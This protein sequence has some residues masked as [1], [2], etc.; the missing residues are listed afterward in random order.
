[1]IDFA[2]GL[3][4]SEMFTV[5]NNFDE[6][7]TYDQYVENY[8]NIKKTLDSVG[9]YTVLIDENGDVIYP[10]E[11]KH[12]Y[13]EDELLSL[14]K[15][16][17][18]IDGNDFESILIPLKDRKNYSQLTIIPADKLHTSYSLN[19]DIEDKGTHPYAYMIL[20]GFLI[21]I[22]GTIITMRFVLVSTDRKIVE[23]ILDLKRDMAALS[24]PSYDIEEKTYDIVELNQMR[25]SFEDMAYTLKDLSDKT[26]SDEFLRSKLISELGHD[27]KNAL[28]PLVGYTN[29]LKSRDYI[30]K[31]D[32]KI[33]QAM[34]DDYSYIEIMLRRLVDYGKLR[35]IDYH[36]N[37]TNVDIVELYKSIIVDKYQN[38]ENKGIDQ[39]IEIE[40]KSIEVLIDPL[41]MKRAISNIV[42]NG[43]THNPEGSVVKFSYKDSKDSISLIIADKGLDIKPE[44][45]EYIF[46]PFVRDKPTKA[47]IGHSGLGLAISK[48][49]IEKHNGK[50]ILSQPYED[51]TKAFIIEIPK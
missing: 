13:S 14:L 51:F 24:T 28:T 7:L 30:T 4:G 31:D 44:I 8:P 39:I 6:E 23:P 40:D 15:G 3:V 27:I 22:I 32:K 11:K 48:K 5:I 37:K 17:H 33:L 21:F 12:R 16:T 46:E 19:L 35:R 25:K 47:S 43:A 18:R 1:M 41:E 29:I 38:F 49:I 45:L 34:L 2:I 10:V 50:L 36:L 26:Q 42:D 9:G 20:I